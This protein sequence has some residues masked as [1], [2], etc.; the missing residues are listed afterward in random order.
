MMISIFH[1]FIYKN[2]ELVKFINFLIIKI[3]N[4]LYTFEK[5]R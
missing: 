2:L 1:A 4:V 5:M 3:N